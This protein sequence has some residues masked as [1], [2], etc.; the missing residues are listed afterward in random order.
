MTATEQI[1]RLSTDERDFLTYLYECEKAGVAPSITGREWFADR[2]RY[3]SALS[4]LL[5]LG[6]VEK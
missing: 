1:L 6:L 4:V 3:L 5:S 2:V